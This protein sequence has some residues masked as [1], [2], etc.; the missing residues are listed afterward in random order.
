MTVLVC[1]IL[2]V[3]LFSDYAGGGRYK[4]NTKEHAQMLEKLERVEERLREV[5]M[6]I[7]Q[8]EHASL[9]RAC[10]KTNRTP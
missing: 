7:A 10:R 4:Q 3:V 1:V 6:G 9:V 8:M 5:S 2:I